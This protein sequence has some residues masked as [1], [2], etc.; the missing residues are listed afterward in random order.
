[1]LF[2]ASAKTVA[3][4]A[5]DG[6]LFLHLTDQFVHM[7]GY[8]PGISEA[9]SW[10]RSIPVLAAA[11]NDA[12]LGDVEMMLEYALPLNSKRADVVLA[13]VH[14]STGEPSY[15]VVELK[16]WSEVTPMRTIPRCATSSATPT[17][18][19]TPSSRSVATVTTWSTS[20]VRSPNT[21]TGSAEWRSCTTPPSSVSPACGR[22]SATAADCCSRG[23][24]AANSSIISV[25]N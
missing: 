12:G 2:R 18:S 13:G 15:V 4:M 23:N 25:R 16:Q 7:H 10:E 24:A 5:F 21:G 9:R 17:P 8:R 1:M 3:V 11:L 20:T 19:S 22:S 6:S 14:P